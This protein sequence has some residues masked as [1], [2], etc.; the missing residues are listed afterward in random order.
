MFKKITVLS[1]LV[2]IVMNIA[3][4]Q[5]G[6]AKIYFDK[7]GKVSDESVAYYYRQKGDKPDAY[8]SHYVNGEGLFFEGIIKNAS[9]SDE[10][11]N[12]YNGT[13]TWYHKNG[14]K[15]SERTYNNDGIEHG[16]SI[17][18]YESGKIWKEIEYIKGKLANNSYKEYDEDGQVSKIFEEDFNN[19]S[20][21]WDLYT[22]DKNSASITNGNF[23]LTSFTKD[24]VSRYISLPSSSQEF[25]LEAIVNI[26]KLKNGEKAGLIFGFKDWQNYNFFLI[27]TNSFYIGFVYEG[28]SSM[29]TEGMF[30]SD[31]K[32]DLDNNIKI[33]SNGEKNVYSI[34]GSIQFKTDRTRNFGSNIGFAVS[35]KSTFSIDKMIY[36]EIDFK[37]TGAIASSNADRDVKSTGSGLMFSTSGYIIT[38]NHVIDNSNK[39]TIEMN[40]KGVVKSYNA[41]VAQKDIDNDIAVIKIKDETFVPID[42]I[43]YAFKESGAAD[44]GASVF[45]IGY[46]FALSGMGKG[47]KFT[48][49]KISSKTGYNGAINSYQTSI[50]VQPGNSGGPIFNDKGEF[51]GV[52][53][54]KIMGADNVSYAIK[55][56]YIKNLIELLPDSPLFPND[57]SIGLSTTEEKVKVLS[58]Y[59]VLIKIK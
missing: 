56:N 46:P 24:G 8:I 3:F 45:T 29:K 12:V 32:K 41:V 6:G 40:Y 53:N 19:N 18:Y 35:G 31:I 25:A 44:V 17:Y 49:G 47:A 43:R 1:T 11:A 9:D 27:T 39:I 59:V 2:I 57:Q 13:C 16:T 22:S 14:K 20:N 23:T 52:I 55:L 34:N 4:A 38:N 42:P 5:N 30:S 28:V 33:L 36:K 51:I 10:G 37:S 54:S 7:A 15:K 48:D 21:D 58:E 50:P 26:S